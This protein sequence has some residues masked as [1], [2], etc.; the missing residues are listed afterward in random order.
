MVYLGGISGFSWHFGM[1]I[2]CFCLTGRKD[3]SI[4]YSRRVMPVRSWVFGDGI[5]RLLSPF[6]KECTGPL[7]GLGMFFIR[8]EI[9]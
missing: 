2:S 6:Y 8:D 5:S 1:W 7:Q 4:L 9:G 3:F